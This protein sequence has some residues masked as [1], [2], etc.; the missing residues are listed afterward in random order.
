MIESR[1]FWSIPDTMQYKAKKKFGQNFLKDKYFVQK[2]VQSIPKILDSEQIIEIGVGL[3]DLS[4][5]L[6]KLYPLKAYEI[7]SDLCSFL[8]QKYDK[9]LESG[10]FT[11]VHQDVCELKESTGW[12]HPEAYI[13]VSNL[14]YYVA[15]HIILKALRDPLC[16]GFIVMVQK[17][18][19]LKFCASFNNSDFCALSVLA[20]TMGEV[21]Y[22]FDVPK[23]AFNPEPKVTSAVFML[24]KNKDFFELQKLESF[25]K[26]A[27]SAPR[28]KLSKNLTSHFDRVLVDSIFASLGISEQTRA[29]ELSTQM[30]HQIFEKLKDKNGK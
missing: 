6:L 24:K 27:F 4:D 3:G 13:L 5:E 10:Y 22:L 28:K 2:I 7:D 9:V 11:L 14:P 19:A 23:E 26:I 17:E 16:K 15:T 21:E 20:Q 1:K 25:L 8:R 29:H 18:V 30:Y 12:L